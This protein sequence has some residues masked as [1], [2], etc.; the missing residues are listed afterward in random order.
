VASAD[1]INSFKGA[2]YITW[3]AAVDPDCCE[4]YPISS[5]LCYHEAAITQADFIMFQHIPSDG[6]CTRVRCRCK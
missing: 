3:L 4:V 1:V 6:V 2:S 5:H